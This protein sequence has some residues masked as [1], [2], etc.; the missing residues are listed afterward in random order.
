MDISKVKEVTPHI[1]MGMGIAF[2]GTATVEGIIQTFKLS[3][4]GYGR[5]YIHDKNVPLKEK[6]MTFGRY[7]WKVGV[8]S[9]IALGCFMGSMKGYSAQVAN[10][11]SIAAWYKQYAKEYKMENRELY[12]VENDKN[13][14]HAIAKKHISKNP[15]KVSQD[16]NELT[17]Y[18][19]ITQQ[20]FYATPA[21]LDFAERCMNDI[22]SKAEPVHYWFL[23]KHFRG[24]DWD[25]PICKEIGWHLDDTYEDYHY[26]NESFFGHIMFRILRDEYEDTP[27]GRV[28]FLRFNIEPML[29]LE[30]DADVVKDSQDLQRL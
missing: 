14:E 1:L 17:F 18:D 4:D 25:R 28:Y 21:E 16:P 19:P 2:S 8:P 27:N 11:V 13:I 23:L 7:Y 20:T 3:E 26:W 10:A 30:L 29:N 22:L 15:P 5:D 9:A 6:V 24:V 12:G